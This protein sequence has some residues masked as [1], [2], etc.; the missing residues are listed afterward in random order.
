M[1]RRRQHL[2]RN[3]KIPCILVEGGY[4]SNSHEGSRLSDSSY[5]EKIARAVANA[6]REQDAEGDGAL[7]P[8]P[9]FIKAPLSH[10]GDAR[11]RR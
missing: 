1:V 5:R 3:P 6:I 10:H 4:I 11:D 2:P 7:G 8:L 9:P